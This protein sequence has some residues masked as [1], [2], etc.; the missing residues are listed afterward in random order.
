MSAVDWGD[1]GA[2]P[3]RTALAWR[4]TAVGLVTVSLLAVVAGL[5]LQAAGLT[6][7]A[8]GAALG[9]ALGALRLV[10][11]GRADRAPALDAFGLLVLAVGVTVVLGGLGVA[12][13]I[14]AVVSAAPG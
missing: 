10:P 1:P 8:L 9:S 4:R 7:T 13:G 14:V 6:V 3:Q 11:A 5:R 2:Q 12:A